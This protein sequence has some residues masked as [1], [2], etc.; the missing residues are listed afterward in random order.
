LHQALYRILEQHEH[1]HY[2]EDLQTVAR[3]VHHNSIHGEC[4]GGGNGY[5]P[6][7][8]DL[9]RVRL[10]H[11]GCFRGEVLSGALWLWVRIISI[12]EETCWFTLEE[13]P[14]LGYPGGLARFAF[15]AA[16]GGSSSC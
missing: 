11:S 10:V 12:E 15:D 16:L 1:H 7:F 14:S 6:R 13:G 3:H 5:F 4:L 8:L 9:Q 2:A